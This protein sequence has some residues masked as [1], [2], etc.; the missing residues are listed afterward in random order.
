[1]LMWLEPHT[2]RQ[3]CDLVFV[4]LNVVFVLCEDSKLS[5][6]CCTLT[7]P[8][9]AAPVAISQLRHYKPVTRAFVMGPDSSSTSAP[10]ANLLNFKVIWNVDPIIAEPDTDNALVWI[11]SDLQC[12]S[13][14]RFMNS[15]RKLSEKP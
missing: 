10:A 2:E 6:V 13:T 9:K 5:I 4:S 11:D 15:M 8:Y 12:A 1:M 7:S 14:A 3:K